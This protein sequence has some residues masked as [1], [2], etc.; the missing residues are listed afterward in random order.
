MRIIA[1][2]A[3][4]RPVTAPPAGTRPT[5]DRVRESVFAMLEARRDLDG[6]RVLDLYAGSG[7]LALEAI[8]RGAGHATLVDSDARAVAV[9]LTALISGL[10]EL[11]MLEPSLFP[12]VRSGEQSIDTYLAG[13]RLSATA[14]SADSSRA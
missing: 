9:G 7:A 10:I 1:G 6:V 5:T 8:S 12:L 13:L 11:W 14:P 2:A 3:G 4:G